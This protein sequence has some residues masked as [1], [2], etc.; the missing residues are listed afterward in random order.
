MVDQLRRSVEDGKPWFQPELEECEG[1]LSSIALSRDALYRGSAVET[2][3][4][5]NVVLYHMMN[6]YKRRAEALE[7]ELQRVTKK[8]RDD[9]EEHRNEMGDLQQQLHDQVATNNEFAQVNLRGAHTIVRK[10]RAGLRLAHCLDDLV[11]AIELVSETHIGDEQMGLRFIEMKKNEIMERAD[12][13]IQLLVQ[14]D[15]V[16]PESEV[17]RWENEVADDFL[18]APHGVID[19]TGEETE[20]ELSEEDTDVEL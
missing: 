12:V 18:V 3:Q 8:A 17:E 1:L 6:F 16:D 4:A 20:E 2:P 10:H 11:G 5:S 13:A 7:E 14:R 9:Y 19:L 15:F